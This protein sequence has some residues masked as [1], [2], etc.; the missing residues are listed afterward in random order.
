MEV[1]HRRE[2]LVDLEVRRDEPDPALRSEVVAGIIKTA[3]T[4]TAPDVG[5]STPQ[6]I[7]MSV[8]FPAPFRPATIGIPLRSHRTTHPGRSASG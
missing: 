5:D 1:F 4:V 6:S 8:D 3:S 2:L 7:L